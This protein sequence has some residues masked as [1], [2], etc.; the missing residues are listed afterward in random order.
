MDTPATRYPYTATLPIEVG[1][2]TLQRRYRWRLRLGSNE[3][4]RVEGQFEDSNGVWRELRNPVSLAALYAHTPIEARAYLSFTLYRLR[5][6]MFPPH[7]RER[8]ELRPTAI[9][10]WLLSQDLA[11]LARRATGRHAT[12]SE[13]MDYGRREGPMIVLAPDGDVFE[14]ARA[15]DA[16]EDARIAADQTA[17]AERLRR[18]TWREAT[19][20]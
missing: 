13:A 11:E 17:R 8:A 15:R 14:V 7:H 4:A 9:R 2:A 16:A 18:M 12:R 3:F 5:V 19:A 6:M 10:E 20:T 1:G